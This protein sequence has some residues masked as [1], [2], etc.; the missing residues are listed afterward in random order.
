MLI[1]SASAAAG[2]AVDGGFYSLLDSWQQQLM[3]MTELRHAGLSKDTYYMM[4]HKQ[5]KQQHFLLSSSPHGRGA[6]R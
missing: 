3:L 4:G 5:H 6:T 1:G 2:F